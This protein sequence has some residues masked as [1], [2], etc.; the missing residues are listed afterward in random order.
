M[1]A[2][3][4]PAGDACKPIR[5]EACDTPAA[6]ARIGGTYWTPAGDTLH[7]FSPA[8]LPTKTVSLASHP[9]LLA[10]RRRIGPVA[11]KDPPGRRLASAAV[12]RSPDRR[13]AVSAVKGILGKPPTRGRRRDA[14]AP[15]R[16][17]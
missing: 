16:P 6:P 14:C 4:H 10:H 11:G 13:T 17:P 5:M 3:D 7:P 9:N 2:V 8:F 15:L 1:S 12:D